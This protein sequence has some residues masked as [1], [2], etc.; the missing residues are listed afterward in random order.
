MPIAST[1]AEYWNSESE[2][3]MSYLDMLNDPLLPSTVSAEFNK[4]NTSTDNN[5]I[6]A[7]D[8]APSIAGDL[9]RNTENMDV[10]LGITNDSLLTVVYKHPYK[11]TLLP[12]FFLF[13]R[14]ISTYFD[15]QSTT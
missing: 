7:S 5:F 8:A 15:C 14:Y 6:D 1:A 3:G 12:L 10:I 11:K 2:N 13:L 4:E 9:S